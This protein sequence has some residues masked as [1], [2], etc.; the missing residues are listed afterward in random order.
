MYP[1]YQ[2]SLSAIICPTAPGVLQYFNLMT[3][4]EVVIAFPEVLKEQANYA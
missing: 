1:M 4:F 2:H 3:C